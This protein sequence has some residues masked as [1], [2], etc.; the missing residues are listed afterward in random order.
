MP[1]QQAYDTSEA[2]VGTSGLERHVVHLYTTPDNCFETGSGNSCELAGTDFSE[3]S[4]ILE[5]QNKTTCSNA[6][7]AGDCI[8]ANVADNYDG[9]TDLGLLGSAG[10]AN[11]HVPNFP[12]ATGLPAFDTVLPFSFRSAT[13]FNT[14]ALG[15]I[16]DGVVLAD[17]GLT[18]TGTIGVFFWPEQIIRTYRGDSSSAN[19]NIPCAT[20]LSQDFL[21]CGGTAG[22]AST[23]V[24]PAAEQ[25][26]AYVTA[27]PSTGKAVPVPAFAAAALGLGLVATTILTGRRRNVA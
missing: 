13:N 4:F 25:P 1:W 3:F 21:T 26:F 27:E 14:S 17:S 16:T 8:A 2:G 5:L 6:P 19:F 23:H 9:A 18:A 22:D 7:T 15:K 20:D 10:G 24:T 11:L 12:G